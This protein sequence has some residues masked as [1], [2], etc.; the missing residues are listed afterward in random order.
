MTETVFLGLGANLGD[1]QANLTAA[2]PAQ[3]KRGRERFAKILP[4]RD[5]ALGRARTAALF[6]RGCLLLL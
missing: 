1:R 6:E 5:R 4:V 2:S 3:C